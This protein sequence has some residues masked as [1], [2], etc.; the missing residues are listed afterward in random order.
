[1]KIRIRFLYKQEYLPTRCHRKTRIRKK[2]G[3]EMVDVREIVASDFPVAFVVRRKKKLNDV[4]FFDNRF[5]IQ[6][7][8]TRDNAALTVQDHIEGVFMMDSLLDDAEPA[9]SQNVIRKT[10]KPEVLEKI[11][12]EAEKYVIFRGTCWREV[13]E[14]YY[15]VVTLGYGKDSRTGIFVEYG[16]NV[17]IP[18]ENRF[19]ANQRKNALIRARE[20]VNEQGSKNQV[21]QD[22]NIEVMDDTFLHNCVD[23]SQGQSTATT[24]ITLLGGKQ[25][26]KNI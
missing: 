10:S 7:S 4:R 11:K 6:I 21:W 13:G 9:S 25:D 3:S 19:K 22:C 5:W 24:I 26:E 14:P 18:A 16:T 15:S 2:L 8:T 1:M 17:S 23:A 20:L 12:N